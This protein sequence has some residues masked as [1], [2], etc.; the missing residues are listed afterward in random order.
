MSNNF[1]MPRV[2]LMGMQ[3]YRE[4]G[5][6]IKKLKFKKAFI[7]TNKGLIERGTVGK[8][9]AVLEE[10]GVEYCIWDG[11]VPNPTVASVNEGFEKLT[12]E[13]NCDFLL[14]IGGGSFHDTAKAI[15]ILAT[16]GGRIHDYEGANQ[17]TENAFPHIAI[18]TTSGT[19][20]QITRFAVITDEERKVKMVIVDDR[21]TPVVSVDDPELMATMPRELTASTGMDA[22]THA[23]E[24]YVS[25]GATLLTDTLALKAIELISSYLRRA[26]WNPDDMEARDMMTWAEHIAGMAFNNGLLGYVHAIA[27]QLGGFYDLPHGVCNALLL[28]HVCEFN[29]KANPKKFRDIAKA[30]GEN[31]NKLSDVDGAIKAIE[32]I[33]TL[34]LDIKIPQKLSE[35]GVVNDDIPVLAKNTLNDVCGLANPRR[36]NLFDIIDILQ[37]AY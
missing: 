4:I 37:K 10:I 29:S 34:S 14:S 2:N 27:H 18:N 15:G 17:L 21:I 3:S 36:A 22:L 30:M 35:L 26:V 11:V 28:P 33:K 20:S 8:V 16:N 5:D 31:V 25:T 12:S 13:K 1:F 9:L 19:A 24:A 6:E 23:V 7:L 32:A